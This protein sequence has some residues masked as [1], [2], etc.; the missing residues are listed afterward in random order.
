MSENIRMVV[1]GPCSRIA[2]I[3]FLCGI[4]ASCKV[5]S[6]ALVN[7]IYKEVIDQRENHYELKDGDLVTVAFYNRVGDLN[8]NDARVLPDGRTD[9]FFM[10]NMRLSGKTVEEVEFE[11]EQRMAPQVRTTDISV[12]ISNRPEVVY[13]VG[14]FVNP[15]VVV[16]EKR[17]TLQQA[18]SSA[19]GLEI[20]GD[21]DWALLRRPHGNPRRP[22]LFRIDLSDE[23]E[24]I[25]LLPND[26]IV[27]DRNF[28]ATVIEYIQEFLSPF[29][30]N[31]V[32]AV[33]LSGA[34]FT[35]F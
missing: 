24:D 23:S 12:R 34:G 32:T 16:L 25:F 3:A 28:V 26:Q 13:M 20:T 15:S 5:T 2:S 30:S 21:T 22:D 11:L 29:L 8:Q 31:Q 14:Q 19:Q 35:A 33:L 7:E 1:Y 27:L 17:M 6:P 9:L 18:I 4:A 10:G